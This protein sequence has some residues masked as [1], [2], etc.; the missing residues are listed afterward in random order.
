MNV[1]FQPGW[2]ASM[3]NGSTGR[4]D[5]EGTGNIEPYIMSGV[6]FVLGNLDYGGSSYFIN[7]DPAYGVPGAWASVAYEYNDTTLGL[8]LDG[9]AERISKAQGGNLQSAVNQPSDLQ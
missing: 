3:P 9:H 6:P 5:D 7:S 8:F 4:R 1:F 2:T